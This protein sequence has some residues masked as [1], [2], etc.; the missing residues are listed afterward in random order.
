VGFL[1]IDH[2]G[3]VANTI[4]QATNVLGGALGLDIDEAKSDWPNG[5][6]F[7]PEQT[8][9]YFFKVGDGLTQV[10]VLIP[11]EGAT[12]GAAR[13]LAQRGPS[14]HHLCYACE[15]VHVEAERLLKNGLTEIDLPRSANGIRTVA[16]F[17]PKSV[18]GVLTE[19]VPAVDTT[20][21]HMPEASPKG[22]HSHGPGH[23]HG[24]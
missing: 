3:L 8:Y 18:G 1:R 22:R 6:Y 10:E 17:H 5:R 9:N 23:T 4:E 21:V 11:A 7:G 19:L 15:D 13:W 16:F 20:R 24:S 14:L 12:S 2:V